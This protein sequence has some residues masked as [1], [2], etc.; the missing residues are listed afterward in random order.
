[1]S[2]RLYALAAAALILAPVAPAV[3]Q[4]APVAVQAAPTLSP[5]D[6]AFQEKGVAFEAKA[7]QMQL[8]LQAVVEDASLDKDTKLSR[9]KA[10]V[11]RYQPDFIAFAEVIKTYLT[12]VAGRPEAAEYREQILAGAQTTSDQIL[13]APGMI[14]TSIEQALNAP[15]AAP[16]APAAPQ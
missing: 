12:G 9:S 6:Q 7:N 11:D 4:D 3:A 10:I 5:E 15:A 13:A 1:M 16:A 8:E 14:L 2:A